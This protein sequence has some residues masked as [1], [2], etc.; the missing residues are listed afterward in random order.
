MKSDWVQLTLFNQISNRHYGLCYLGSL[1]ALDPS[2]ISGPQIA[3]KSESENKQE[4]RTSGLGA[5]LGNHAHCNS[6]SR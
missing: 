2:A 3:E 4:S 1:S 5:R 6:V